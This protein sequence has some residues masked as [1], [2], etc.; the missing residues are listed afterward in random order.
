MLNQASR[1]EYATLKVYTRGQLDETEFEICK[2]LKNGN[3]THLDYDH[4]RFSME[5]FSISHPS[6]E[7]H[8]LV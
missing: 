8:C 7:C 4:V 1:R 3:V 5:T 2:I 6:G